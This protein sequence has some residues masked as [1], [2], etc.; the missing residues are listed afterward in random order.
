[1]S[2]S[3]LVY[4]APNF[5]LNRNLFDAAFDRDT[6]GKPLCLGDIIRIAKNRSS[7][8]INKRNFVLLGD[9]AVK[10]SYPWHGTVVVDSLNDKP[11]NEAADT[12]KALSIV[13]IS[14]HVEDTEGLLMNSF[15]G[16]V[17]PLVFDKPV[18]VETLAND[19]GQKI[20][21]AVQNNILFS[22]RTDVKNG[23]FS[24]SFIVPRD[25]SYNYGYGKISFYASDRAV[26]LNGYYKDIITGGFSN[27]SLVDTTGPS[28]RIFLN[29]TLF[30]NG[31]LTDPDPEIYAI[32]EDP[33]GINATGSGIGH[34]IIS[35][36]DDDRDNEIV[37]NNYF[38]NDPGSFVK[39]IISYDLTGL[40]AGRHSL[41]LKAW[42]NFNNSSEKSLSF[43]VRADPQFILD[44]LLNFPNPTS[45]STKI[46]LGHNRPGET[47]EVTITIYS[48]SGK[49]VR[50]I[51]ATAFSEGYQ[52]PPIDWDGNDSGGCRVG[53]GIYPYS[54]K[55]RSEKGETCTV[56]GRMIIL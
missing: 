49:V 36:I 55:I 7:A 48:L 40:S 41:H 54:V 16:T 53:K 26:D 27:V 14:G 22:G 42:D 5:Q 44:N 4:S 32:L 33:S 51:K 31:G 24:F 19:G 2:T 13:N 23:R 37:L 21:F 30:I 43:I 11:V 9:P 50:I 12:I 35:W 15:D 56:S 25:I 6:D 20:I 38:E 29:D 47:L 17:E 34:D 8:G 10:L 18:M 52:L 46:T 45:S 28:I 1:M 39:G 3:R